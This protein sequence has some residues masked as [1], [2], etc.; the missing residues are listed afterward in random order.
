MYKT[1][2]FFTG[3]FNFRNSRL[4][5][6]EGSP[7][8]SLSSGPVESSNSR[9]ERE[10][11][12]ELNRLGILEL[13]QKA[14]EIERKMKRP[15]YKGLR[16]SDSNKAISI[17]IKIAS[18]NHMVPRN[19]EE[20][21]VVLAQ[22]DYVFKYSAKFHWSN[23]SG[24]DLVLNRKKLMEDMNYDRVEE[25]YRKTEKLEADLK[26]PD[27]KGDSSDDYGEILRLRTKIARR[28]VPRNSVEKNI[29]IDCIEYVLNNSVATRNDEK[30]EGQLEDRKKLI[31][32]L[33]FTPYRW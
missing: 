30:K 4:V 5:Y 1:N 20:R 27:Y 31:R 16:I 33:E 3:E 15:G 9:E 13:L 21:E 22:I 6:K 12:E 25:V 23:G 18:D 7:D 2:L 19:D 24:W 14:E 17:R 11:L 10:E 26:D 32:S 28:L 29:V 8:E